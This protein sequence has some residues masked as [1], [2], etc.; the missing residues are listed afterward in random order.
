M[1]VII[2]WRKCVNGDYQSITNCPLAQ[3]LR[4]L[5]LLDFE[6][7]NTM[8]W[9]HSEWNFHAVTLLFA[10]SGKIPWSEASMRRA[11]SRHRSFVLEIPGL[12]RYIK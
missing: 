6:V 12:E 10:Q 11:A 5:G 9:L 4:E 3:T 2:S 1:K 8:L 7:G